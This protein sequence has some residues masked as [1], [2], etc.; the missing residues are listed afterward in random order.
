MFSWL[1]QIVRHIPPLHRLARKV[2]MLIFGSYAQKIVELQ[3]LNNEIQKQLQQLLPYS[4]SIY[5]K[6]APPGHYYSPIPDQEELSKDQARI[7]MQNQREL[8]GVDLKPNLMLETLASFQPYYADFPFS[9]DPNPKFRFYLDNQVYS[10]GDAVVL[11]SMMRSLK[12]QQIIE[13]GSGMSTCLMLDVNEIFFD[14][15]ISIKSI[16]PYPERAKKLLRPGDLMLFDFKTQR[17]QDVNTGVFSEL[18]A[19]DIVF[20]DSTHVSKCGSDVNYIFFEILPILKAGVFVHFHDTFYPFEYPKQWLLE[21]GAAWNECYM[22]RAFLQYNLE[23]EVVFFSDYM[24]RFYS[25]EVEQVLLVFL[26]GPGSS[27]WL[28]KGAG[29]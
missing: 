15:Q 19:N 29:A 4:E 21:I 10:R 17:L 22:L 18:H 20:I 3:T 11:Y 25:Q 1:R 6:F 2:W 16:D 27:I 8:T 24:A 7:F 26:E 13:V 12:P 28:R 5:H 14:N 23:F 9:E